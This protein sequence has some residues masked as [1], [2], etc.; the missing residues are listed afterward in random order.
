MDASNHQLISQSDTASLSVDKLEEG[1]RFTIHHRPDGTSLAYVT[2]S[3][4]RA[5]YLSSFLREESITGINEK[6]LVVRIWETIERELTK[7]G[8]YDINEGLAWMTDEQKL[9]VSSAVL[10]MAR[11]EL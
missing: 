10:Y 6:S 11:E 4:E 8:D 5:R 1:I 3:Y 9:A 2:I 7:L